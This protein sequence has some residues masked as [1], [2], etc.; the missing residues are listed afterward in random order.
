MARRSLD[1]LQF[2]YNAIA[3][4]EF[5][6]SDAA[7][8]SRVDRVPMFQ[9]HGYDVML[10]REYDSGGSRCDVILANSK[11]NPTMTVQWDSSL[12]AMVVTVDAYRVSDW[13]KTPGPGGM[14]YPTEVFPEPTRLHVILPWEVST[15]SHDGLQGTV[16][17]MIN[18]FRLSQV[19]PLGPV[20]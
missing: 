18:D 20:Q 13:E 5:L 1:G 17:S 19:P 8:L 9:S 10:I 16:L 7:S 6:G 11:T 12:H 2:Y 14:T 4:G 15:L 3:G